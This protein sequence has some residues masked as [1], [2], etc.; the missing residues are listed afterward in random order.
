M[1]KFKATLGIPHREAQKPANHQVEKHA[2]K[3]AQAGLV[4]FDV[5]AIEAPGTDHDVS[6]F[7]NGNIEE[8]VQFFDRGGK[9]RVS[10]EHIFA[11]CGQHSLTYGVSLAVIVL[12]SNEAQPF[13]LK[14]ANNCRCIDP[15]PVID[16]NDFG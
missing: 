4:V 9:V 5:P 2:A 10:E 6:A 7:G 11:P 14:L 3:L 13:R 1:K 8:L 15:G 16:N 12:V